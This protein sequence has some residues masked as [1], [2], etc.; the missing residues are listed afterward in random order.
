MEGRILLKIQ[1]IWINLLIKILNYIILTRCL[2]DRKPKQIADVQWQ[3]NFSLNISFMIAPCIACFVPVLWNIAGEKKAS[4]WGG[5]F[6]FKIRIDFMFNWGR[7]SP[8]I[9]CLTK[10]SKSCHI[11]NMR[12]EVL[13]MWQS[14][15][16]T[17]LLF[18]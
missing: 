6:M 3:R 11:K 16:D 2:C 15:A 18:P 5:N 9:L 8:D 12:F 10:L 13:W 7:I 14:N 4:V 1:N 17:Q